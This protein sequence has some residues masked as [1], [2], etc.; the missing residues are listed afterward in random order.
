M[1]LVFEDG[2]LTKTKKLSGISISNSYVSFNKIK[3]KEA[4]LFTHFGISG[5][6]ILQI[7]SYIEEG[8]FININFAPELMFCNA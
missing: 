5:P 2:L 4:V 8:D 3:F 6:A 1:P 7:S